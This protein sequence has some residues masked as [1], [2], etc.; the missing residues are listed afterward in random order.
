MHEATGKEEMQLS[1]FRETNI[2]N[3]S[4]SKHENNLLDRVALQRGGNNTEGSQW[5]EKQE[6]GI[7]KSQQSESERN[8][9]I[10]E[11]AQ[12]YKSCLLSRCVV[13]HAGERREECTHRE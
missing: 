3:M 6:G 9:K 13:F 12:E 11:V 8:R 2:C 5:N 4:V 7:L 1:G 10:S